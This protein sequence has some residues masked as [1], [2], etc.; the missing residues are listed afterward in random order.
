MGGEGND[1]PSHPL[2][3]Y[4]AAYAIKDARIVAA[5]GKSS[6]RARSWSGGA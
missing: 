5:P 4:P 3:G 1:D 6:T 2:D